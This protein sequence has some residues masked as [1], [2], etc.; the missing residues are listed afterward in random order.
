MAQ[1]IQRAMRIQ[2]AR[3]RGAQ[4]GIGITR[5]AFGEFGVLVGL[6]ALDKGNHV[7][8]IQ[9]QRLVITLTAALDPALREQIGDQFGFK[10][11]F[12][13]FVHTLFLTSILPVTAALI[14]LLLRSCS[15]AMAC[16]ALLIR[17]S[18]LAVWVSKYSAIAILFFIITC[19]WNL[20]ILQTLSR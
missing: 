2:R 20:Q 8:G 1:A 19:Y 7:F 12:F 6:R 13:V 16:L 9:R 18:I 4:R 11:R 15:K 10:N 5:I 17:V 14:R 3:N